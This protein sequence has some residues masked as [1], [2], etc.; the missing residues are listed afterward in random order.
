M[1]VI[2]EWLEPGGS[3]T[4]SMSFKF[5]EDDDEFA[6]RLERELPAK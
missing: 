3:V 2:G 5:P 4:Q 6:A 1:T